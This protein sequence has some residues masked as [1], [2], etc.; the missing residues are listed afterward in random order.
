[1]TDVRR[2]TR[3]NNDS[4][5]IG[6]SV[7]LA[8]PDREAWLTLCGEAKGEWRTARS[9]VLCENCFRV[10]RLISEGV[11]AMTAEGLG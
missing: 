7:H 3:D 2:I 1:M 4:A 11:D 6:M 9:E 10:G 8:K 5:H